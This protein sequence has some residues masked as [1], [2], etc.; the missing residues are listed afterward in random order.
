V[1][2]FDEANPPLSELAQREVLAHAGHP[3]KHWLTIISVQVEDGNPATRFRFYDVATDDF[4]AVPECA[5]QAILDI[6]GGIRSRRMTKA[7][8]AER[9]EKP[10]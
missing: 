6:L 1:S 3:A 9:G 2:K 4:I 8:I 10:T 5:A 7:P